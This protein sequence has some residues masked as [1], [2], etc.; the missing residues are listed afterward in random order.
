MSIGEREEADRRYI[1]KAIESG[2]SDIQKIT[3]FWV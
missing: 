3:N 2:K 1:V